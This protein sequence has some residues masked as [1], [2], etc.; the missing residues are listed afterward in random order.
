MANET[1]RAQARIEAP[2]DIGL[3]L[4]RTAKMTEGLL[5]LLQ[6]DYVEFQAK[7]AGVPRGFVENLQGLTKT[8]NDLTLAHA[9]YRKTEDEWAE[10]LSPEQKLEQLQGYLL[11]LYKDRPEFV[12]NWIDR[13]VKLVNRAGDTTAAHRGRTIKAVRTTDDRLDEP[14]Y[15]PGYAPNEAWATE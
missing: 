8:L 1:V 3:L 11:H 4:Q 6:A 7:K 9:R 5:D 10:K 12:A 13:T 14:G 2:V 15:S